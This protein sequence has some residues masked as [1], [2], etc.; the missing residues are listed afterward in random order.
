MDIPN[1]GQAMALGA[2]YNARTGHCTNASILCDTL[3]ST[4]IE[5]RDENAINS[6]V[7]SEDS[8]K[9][10]FKAFE[11]DGNLKLN[12]LA[13]NV[14][15]NA[16]F[17]YLA[18]EKKSSK[19]VKVSMSYAVQTKLERINIRA[20][21]MR[22]Y[23][24]LKTLKDTDATHVVT[25]IQWG[26][27]M[28]C[29]FEHSL[30]EGETA[31]EIV[32]ILGTACN[33]LK[34]GATITGD[35]KWNSRMSTK[36]MSVSISILGDIV[37]KADSYPTSIEDAIQ[38]MRR[39]PESV[40]GVNQ[41]KGSVL[42]YKLEPIEK[43]R[44]HFDL[45]SR[46]E[47]VINNVRLDLVDK[48]ESTF[49]TIVEN[50][51]RLTEASNDI[52]KYSQY[53]A[54]T[55]VKRIK[56]EL[57]SFNRDE[58][59]FKHSLS[60]TVQA[61]QAGEASVDE[62]F[63]L[64]EDFEEGSC[65]SSM[66]DDVIESYQDLTSRILF[67]RRCEKI[68][69]QVISRVDEISNVLS[70]S[71]KDKTFI[72]TI[73]K[74]SDYTMIEQ[75]HVWRIFRFL[76]EDHNDT[77]TDFTIHDASIS[78]KNLQMNDLTE[79]T[80]VKYH[81]GIKSDQNAFRASILRP[82]IKLSST[83][84]VDQA[85]RTKLAGH[86]LRMPCPSS[87][88]DECHSGALKWVCFKCEEVMQY[89][90][91]ELVY[92]RCGKT[93]LEDCTFRCGSIEHGYQYKEL[94]AESIQSI[95]DKIRPGDDEINILLLGETGVGKS[96]FINAFA[97]YLRYESLEIAESMEMTTLIQSKFEFVGETVIA[98]E[99]D[100]NERLS[101]GHSSTQLCRSY[102]FPLNDDIKIR[103]I[104]TPGIGDTRGV[105]H[106]RTNF[107]EIL[108]YISRFEKINGICI[109]LLPDKPRLTPSFRFCIDELL[110][111]L[112]KSTAD[113]ILFTFT[114]TRSS[115]YGPGDTMTPLKT[116]VKELKQANDVTIQL[117]P[118]T[119]FYFDNEAFRLYAALKQGR[120]FDPK[121]KE[122]FA[123]SWTKSVEEAQRLVKRVMELTPHKTDETVT[124]DMARRS[125]ILLAPPL[126]RINENITIELKNIKKH[127]AEAENNEMSAE[128]LKTRL[129]CSYMDLDPINLARPRM[130]CTSASCTTI[131]GEIVRYSQHC[132]DKCRVDSLANTFGK[133]I[134]KM[135][136][137]MKG[138]K[139][140]R[141]CGCDWA[142]HMHVRI[143]YTEV[144]KQK[145]DPVVEQEL[146][147][148]LS[149][150]DIMNLAIAAADER[151]MTLESEKKIIFDSLMTFTGFLLQNSILVQNSGIGDYID[152]SIENQAKIAEN[153]KDYSIVESLKAQKKELIKQVKIIEDAIKD[154][155]SHAAKI[156]A[157]EVINARE[158]LCRLQVNGQALAKILDFGKKNQA[159]V[160]ERETRIEGGYVSVRWAAVSSSV[161]STVSSAVSGVKRFANKIGYPKGRKEDRETGGNYAQSGTPLGDE[162]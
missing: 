103:L 147:E 139:T 81:K 60:G 114:K 11:I 59:E 133:E 100:Q 26:A 14:P 32:G 28:L 102:V 141:K 157:S 49:D 131:H 4:L 38:F 89:E 6:K 68:N 96:T 9:E 74:S 151:K 10:K 53:I 65:S 75:S 46:I 31:K 145:T 150:V 119:L 21:K 115:F 153:T 124:L 152:M 137:V 146:N 83:E 87:H 138:W 79:L 40:E 72:L 117:V 33:T 71:A 51:I 50:R 34:V 97:N 91:N 78:S 52:L 109:L 35:L 77:Q 134:L 106:D 69:I 17:K 18:T 140:C 12:I 20:D 104:D 144:K 41:G 86:A 5:S 160:T 158:E 127:K 24:S 27:N 90:Y 162:F 142:K 149:R 120:V 113:N 23:I 122:A 39:V 3:P 70:S 88:E 101:D 76:R 130:V 121:V 63:R 66:V 95:T 45:Q 42:V 64:L 110:L 8:Y 48:V 85:E 47:S 99:P 7:I 94:H 2:L 25:G 132:H 62:L 105:T 19:S 30:E 22:E 161:S 15:L 93:R 123:E 80:I 112:H 98:G 129:I 58:G 61:I 143:D 92:C 55:E 1:L 159:E 43:V 107:E 116:Y 154:G 148:K 67:I 128:E 16:Q 44:A 84:R 125:I 136:S 155:Q 135:C 73:P 108:N 57:K 56:K 29:T 54:E 82:S 111:H 37:P 118:N 126:A 36:D 13:N 156:T